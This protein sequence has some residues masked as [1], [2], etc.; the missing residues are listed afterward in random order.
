M[1]ENYKRLVEL[2]FGHTGKTVDKWE[3]YLSIY[4]REFAPYLES[5]R[6]VRLLEIGVQNGGSLELWGKYLPEGSEIIGIDIDP[7]VGNLTFEGAISAFVVDATDNSKLADALGDRQ[8]DIVVDDGSHISNDI[9]TTFKLLFDRLAPGGKYIIEDLH[10]SYWGS[11]GGGYRF[12]TSAMEFFKNLVDALNADHFQNVGGAEVPELLQFNRYLAGITFYDSVI[13]IEKLLKEKNSPYR[14]MLGGITSDVVDPVIGIMAQPTS[15]VG[16]LML[17]DEQKRYIESSILGRI[18]DEID[19]RSNTNARE[20]SRIEAE[21]Q[22]LNLKLAESSSARE[23]DLAHIKRLEDDLKNIQASAIWRYVRPLRFGARLARRVARTVLRRKATQ[24]GTDQ[25]SWAR[26]TIE[27]AGV[28]DR[29]WYLRNYPDVAAAKIDPLEH[30]VLYGAREGRNPNSRFD[31]KWYLRENFDVVMAGLNPLA[32]YVSSGAME[33][34]DPHPNFSTSWYNAQNPHVAEAKI[35]PLAHYLR[36]GKTLGFSPS[37]DPYRAHT[38]QERLHDVLQRPELLQHID[39]MIYRPSFVIVIDGGNPADRAATIESCRLQLYPQWQIVNTLDEVCQMDATDNLYLVWITAGDRLNE[40]ALYAYASALNADPQ[41]DLVY[42]DEDEWHREGRKRPFYKPGW[43]P[44][45]LEAMNYIGSAACFRVSTA[46]EALSASS[47]LYDFTLRFVERTGNIRHV[48][49]LLLH[50]AH[51]PLSPISAEQSAQDIQALEGRLQ[52]TERHGV[53]S[54]NVADHGCYD[55][56]VSLKQEP[57]VSVVIPTAGKVVAH[58]GR[59]LDLIVNCIEQIQTHSTYKNL[60][61][62]IIDNGDFDRARLAHLDCVKKFATFTEPEFNVAKKLNIGA[63]IASG[64]ILLLMNDDIEPLTPNWIERLLEHFEKPH[65]GVVGAKLL[66]PDLTLQH[67]GVAVNAGN[68][69][70]VRRFSKRDDQGYF[71]STCGTRNYCAVTGAVMMTRAA[72]FQQVGG[73]TES[74]A[75]SFNDVDYCLKV[76]ERGHTIVYAPK[77]ELIHFESKSR[78]PR[79][80]LSELRYFHRRWATFAVDPFYNETNLAVAPP[81]FVVQHNAR[82]I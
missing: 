45:Y 64:P 54:Q 10:A 15:Q 80:D 73:Y 40:K 65:V 27:D 44:D 5:K 58:N 69:D 71:F 49:E 20:I 57:L 59:E 12:G 25:E 41:A 74:L 36:E 33:G 26:S 32:H 3:Q 72:L 19:A 79:L 31:T 35:N 61:F 18:N 55:V 48:R 37:P 75:I 14:R 4:S 62:I 46:I 50:R 76:S 30:Y 47:S 2:F 23:R 81:K 22:Q 77:A 7:K 24:L 67:A 82:L 60:E 53:V 38:N 51:G 70:H 16:A 56:Q 39:V 11:H 52:R 6:P 8:F 68:P 78:E 66:Y 28:F 43:S 13:V 17:A 34:R 1:P 29:Q 9:I 63:S 42:F 21:K